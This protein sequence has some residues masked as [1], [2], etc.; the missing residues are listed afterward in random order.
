[1]SAS[2]QD[3]DTPAAAGMC[4][5]CVSGVQHEGTP[6]G[7]VSKIGPFD[8]VYVARPKEVKN[9]KAAIVFFSDIFGFKLLN[10]KLVA[11]KIANASGINVYMPD[12]FFGEALSPES[13]HL[14]EKPDEIRNEGIF[15]KLAKGA[16][17]AAIIPWY[18]RHKPSQHMAAA[19]EFVSLLKT[20]E[21]GYTKLGAIGYCYG[22]KMV[23]ESNASDLIDASAFVHPSGLSDADI[24][25]LKTPATFALAELDNAFS[26]EM[27]IASEKK[28]KE[29]GVNAEFVVYDGTTH[30]FAVRGDMKE[31][32]TRKGQEGAIAQASGWFGKFLAE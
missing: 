10:N 24:D 12:L 16:K 29:K 15:A 19:K 25:W 30:G 27:R 14:P 32:A 17:I 1:M 9:D 5:A 4:D 18:L 13:L 28:L 22:A 21:H 23:A 2:A 20:N 31:E 7:C 3:A 26:D 6:T 11:D 8:E